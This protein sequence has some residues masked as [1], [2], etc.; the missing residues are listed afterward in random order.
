MSI[1]MILK[2]GLTEMRRKSRLHRLRRIL[3]EKEKEHSKKLTILGKKAWESK[4]NIG[5]L[6]N[7]DELLSQTEE[8]RK[9]ITAKL[10]EL[11]TSKAE[12]EEKLKAENSRFKAQF[13]ELES[14]K[15]PVDSEL[16]I[17]KDKWQ[18]A[19]KDMDSIQRRFKNIPGDEEKIRKKI[20]ESQSNLQ[21]QAEHEKNFSSLQDEKE[22]L[23]QNLQDLAKIIQVSK[24][25]VVPLDEQSN[26]LQDEIRKAKDKH[27]AEIDGM[28]KALSKVKNDIIEWNKKQ[29]E[30]AQQ[31]D[32]NFLALGKK[33]SKGNATNSTLAPPL[34]AVKTVEKDMD[35]IRE[36]IQSLEN[37]KMPTSRGAVW[38]MA[39]LALLFLIVIVGITLGVVWLSRSISGNKMSLDKAQSAGSQ[40][41][42][43]KSSES[44]YLQ[45]QENMEKI[46]AVSTLQRR[47]EITQEEFHQMVEKLE[48]L[49]QAL[50]SELNKIPRETFDPQVIVDTVGKDPER[51]FQWVRDNTYLVPYRGSL[52][53][54]IGVLMDR[55]GN[56]LDRSLLLSKLLEMADYETRLAHAVLTEQEARNLQVK[57]RLVPEK[58]D[59]K[60]EEEV[61]YDSA[62]L[63]RLARQLEMD[64]VELKQDL[65]AMAK[66]EVQQNQMAKK[67]VEEQTAILVDIMGEN[68]IQKSNE[69]EPATQALRDHWWVQ[70]KDSDQWLDFDLVLP[71]GEPSLNMSRAGETYDPGNLPED[72]FHEVKIRIIAERWAENKLREDVVLECKIKPSELMGQPIALNHAA[73]NWPEDLNLL[74]ESDPLNRLKTEVLNEKEWL[75][76]LTI[77]SSLIFQSSFSDS[78]E[79]KKTPGEKSEGEGAGGL[80]RGLFD[81]LAGEESEEK[82]FLTAEWIEYEIQIPSGPTQ[83]I[84]RHV[85]DFIG[86]AARSLGKIAKPEIQDAR[87]LEHGLCLL[88][89]ID[90]LPLTCKLSTQ[91]V[92][93]QMT[94]NLLQSLKPFLEELKE[95][96]PDKI[97]EVTQ[98]ILLEMHALQGP[99]NS[100][101]MRRHKISQ[102]RNDI[103]LH[104][105]NIGNLRRWLTADDKGVLWKRRTFDIVKNDVALLRRTNKEAAIARI[106]QGVA[107]TVAEGLELFS[108]DAQE[109]VS[110]LISLAAQ[111][112]IKWQLI[113]SAQD[114]DWS[115]WRLSSDV[116]D[117]LT[118]NLSSG[119]FAVIPSRPL[120]V[121]TK[122][123]LGW[124]RINPNNGE[125]VGVMDTGFNQPATE[126]FVV[127]KINYVRAVKTGRTVYIDDAALL[128]AIGKEELTRYMGYQGI[129]GFVKRCYVELLRALGGGI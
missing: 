95:G 47:R 124:W 32:H 105:L 113:R 59:L 22:Q 5:P 99:L 86:P 33:L 103:Y 60:V 14:K 89:I 97:Q 78:G 37:Q 117:R 51:L 29:K 52:R 92:S 1:R 87:R 75:P 85:F 53:G 21:A 110:H 76:Y 45:R 64:T 118:Q 104:S 8:K 41:E 79:I 49:Y 46:Q 125:I 68:L 3:A 42:K 13:D 44:D 50:D 23:S 15:R 31:Q 4:L 77:G 26:R 11:N 96:G 20:S 55:L 111:Q 72:L 126:N 58:I 9:D 101:A 69:T 90:I 83:T 43:A 128:H 66:D 25:K 38:K 112:G 88:G 122:K 84:R 62:H 81:A 40:M 18:K 71:H 127:R 24:E 93:W 108:S 54:P 100:W 109:N 7:L 120:L 129:N 57:T 61:V 35:L 34:E 80:R 16:K 19:Q 12:L 56:S 102:F 39:G 70:W 74:E 121:G 98:N 67:T 107:D 63:D 119:Y 30:V 17:E 82:S 73:M 116:Y 94:N 106:N 123:R 91:Y 115:E 28:D 6:G 2:E 48:K 10:Q 36:D 27:K 65:A 114:L